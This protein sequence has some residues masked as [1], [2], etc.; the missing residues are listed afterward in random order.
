MNPDYDLGIENIRLR[1]LIRSG[2]GITL[3]TLLGLITMVCAWIYDASG[4]ST[5]EYHDEPAIS[6]DEIIVG[7][8]FILTI[9]SSIHLLW[10]IVEL[11]VNRTWNE[12]SSGVRWVIL[13]VIGI[14]SFGVVCYLAI[15][16]VDLIS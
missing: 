4:F 9:F 6:L 11:S 7:L 1:G 14:F 3:P 13:P 15:R 5:F 12:I 2:I 8:P 16:I 10:D